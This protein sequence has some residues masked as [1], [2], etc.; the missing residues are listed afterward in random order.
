MKIEILDQQKEI[1]ILHYLKNNGFSTNYISNLRQEVGQI[2]KNGEAVTV[3]EKVKNGD[4][5]ELNYIEREKNEILPI[6]RPIDIIYED[7]DI[8][9]VNKPPK[10][11]VIPTRKHYDRSLS[12]YVT[13]YMQQ[14]ECDFIFRAINRLDLDTSGIVLIAKNPIAQHFILSQNYKKEYLAVLEGILDE[15]EF[16]NYDENYK[17][18][19]LPIYNDHQ[20]K[21]VIINCKGKD[22][23]TA[24]KVLKKD[25]EKNI[26]V[27]S[28]QTITGRTH[29]LRAHFAYYNHP[30]LGDL[31]YGKETILIDRVALHCQTIK[32]IHPTTKEFLTISAEI[33]FDLINVMK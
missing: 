1:E 14:K 19:Q 5:L 16:E 10:L 20:I 28:A 32:F 12:N 21:K 8:I 11:A 9:A 33:P 31:H 24:F 2:Q 13:F 4:I 17:K 18:I 6:N 3:R 23:V 7:D 26:T 29:Q 22:S 15:K 25:Y 30:I 27:V